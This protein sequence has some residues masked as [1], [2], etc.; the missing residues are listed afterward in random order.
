MQFEA[1][2]HSMTKFPTMSTD[3]PILALRILAPREKGIR[4]GTFHSK[5]SGLNV[6]IRISHIPL[7][8]FLNQQG[9]DFVDGWKWIH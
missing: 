7:P 2:L 1:L 8:F 6:N 3:R 5:S 9:I 4:I